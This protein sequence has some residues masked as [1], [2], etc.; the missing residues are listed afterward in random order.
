MPRTIELRVAGGV[1]SVRSFARCA[2]RQNDVGIAEQLVE[3]CGASAP[4][5]QRFD[6]VSGR[7]AAAFVDQRRQPARQQVAPVLR[8]RSES[9]RR[10]EQLNRALGISEG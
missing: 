3:R 10:F 7:N 8:F 9:A 1:E 4:E 2:R 6:V 5:L